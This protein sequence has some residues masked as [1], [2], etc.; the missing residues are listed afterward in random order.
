M[1]IKYFEIFYLF[2]YRRKMLDADIRAVRQLKEFLLPDEETDGVGRQRVF[3]WKNL[4]NTFTL[5]DE[6]NK[7]DV[8]SEEISNNNE[9]D[10]QYEN[11][12]RKMRYERE[13]FLK[14]QSESQKE[15]IE[16]EPNVDVTVIDS[17]VHKLQSDN[18]SLR[19]NELDKFLIA[20][21]LLIDGKKQP[22]RGSFLVRDKVTL[23]KLAG[24][25]NNSNSLNINNM[26][27]INISSIGKSKNFV[28]KTLTAEECEANRK[29]KA[30]EQ[31]DPSCSQGINYIKKPKLQPRR[32]KCIIDLLQE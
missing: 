6:G 22:T 8:N 16:M 20:K 14:E 11:M 27:A 21:N 3:K 26:N 10:E 32:E 17:K 2:G 25:T 12:W 24:L 18:V 1:K 4:Q 23:H 28:F 29:R 19:K 15:S 5:D 30:E 9:T 31:V 13:R 7:N